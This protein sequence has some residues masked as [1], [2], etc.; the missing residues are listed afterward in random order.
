MSLCSAE[1][2][3][4]FMDDC[5][6]GRKLREAGGF[7]REARYEA[8]RSNVPIT[9]LALPDLREL[10]FDRYEQLDDQT[11]SLIRLQRV[12]WPAD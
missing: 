9:L 1:D 5:E 7:T 10:L 11:K 6:T 3:K 12:Y 8:E 4:T 2:F